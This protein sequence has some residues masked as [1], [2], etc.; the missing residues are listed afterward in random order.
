M[1]VLWIVAIASLVTVA[2]LGF[3]LAGVVRRLDELRREV[4][5][6]RREQVVLPDAEHV[7]GGL[8]VGSAAPA[9]DAPLEGGGSLSSSDLSGSM[10]LVVFADPTCDAC[11]A[12]VP[13]LLRAAVDATV[14][15]VVIVGEAGKVWPA[16]WMPPD[17][18]ED[19]AGV[20][21]DEGGRIAG[22]FASGF[23]PHVFVVDEGGFVTAQG[24]AGTLAGVRELLRD[25]EGIRIVPP[26]GAS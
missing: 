24:S 4:D 12:L 11:D 14:P 19:R 20:V 23:S 13:D 22:A 15:P 10:H 16:G 7:E 2:F 26:E 9:F 6:L 17:G 3:A 18:S 21:R 25:A 1:T 8:P 5:E